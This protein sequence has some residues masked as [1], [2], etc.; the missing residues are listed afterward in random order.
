MIGWAWVQ[1]GIKEVDTSVFLNTLLNNKITPKKL[2]RDQQTV[3]LLC[4]A[5]DYRIVAKLARKAGGK[6]CV[7][8]KCGIYFFIKQIL[9]RTGLWLGGIVF[10]LC[11]AFSQSYIWHIRYAGMNYI[12]TKQAEAIL[13]QVGICPGVQSSEE[14]LLKGETAL[15]QEQ[16]GYGWASLNFEKGRLLVETAPAAQIPDIKT[17]SGEDI[18]AKTAGT[19]VEIVTE[20]G[21]PVVKVGDEVQAGDVLIAANRVDRKE[22]PVLGQTA[23]EVIASFVWETECKQPLHYIEAQPKGALKTYRTLQIGKKTFGKSEKEIDG[24]IATRHYPLTCAGMPL[25]GLWTEKNVLEMRKIEGSYSETLAKAK[26]KKRCLEQLQKE[27]KGAKI[28]EEQESF[29]ADGENMY[30]H[31]KAKVQTNIG[32]K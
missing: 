16:I 17:T 29:S 31:Y 26:A 28:T 24:E 22:E 5:K 9:A 8:K 21:T 3:R 25:P 13:R 14:L 18:L 1:C 20:A 4:R 19:I 7:L 30:Y 32:V 12:Q 6:C 10:G 27:W 23:G 2:Q 15:V 11:I